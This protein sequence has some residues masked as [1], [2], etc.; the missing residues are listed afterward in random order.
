M[1]LFVAVI[2]RDFGSIPSA[3]TV[4]MSSLW[5]FL[6]GFLLGF[7]GLASVGLGGVGLGGILLTLGGAS[8]S[9]PLPSSTRLFPFSLSSPGGF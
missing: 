3:G 2:A 7:S 4:P 8:L 9:V 5:G 1:A 6:L